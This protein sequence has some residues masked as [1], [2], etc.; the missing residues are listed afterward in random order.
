MVLLGEAL[1]SGIGGGAALYTALV[2]V[3]S[4]VGILSPLVVPGYSPSAFLIAMA[5]C[6][7]T[8]A[9]LLVDRVFIHRP[10]R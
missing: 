1:R 2:Q 10:V 8:G 3:G 7:V 6:A 5:F 4:T 9:L